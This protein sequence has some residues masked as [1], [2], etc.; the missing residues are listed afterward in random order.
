M[1]IYFSL[2][3][4]LVGVLMYALCINPKLA[5]IGRLM[6]ASGLLAFLLEVAHT[7]LAVLGR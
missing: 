6:F 7:N 5:E 4:A 1:L 2:L 3:V